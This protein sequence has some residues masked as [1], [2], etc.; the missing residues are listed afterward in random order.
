MS[1]LLLRAITSPQ[2]AIALAAASSCTAFSAR[3]VSC[4]GADSFAQ[5]TFSERTIGNYENRLRRFS[6]PERVFAYF[7]SVKINDE[8]FM[9]RD[10]L[11]RAVT[12]FTYRHGAP[13]SSKN[14][15][16]NARASAAKTSKAVA[17]EYLRRVQ[18]ILLE[19]ENVSPVEMKKLL[20]FRDEQ[21]VDFETH[22]KTLRALEITNAE[23]DQFLEL[24]GCLPSRAKTFFDLVD[25]DGD[26][27]ISYAEYSFFCTLLA[28]PEQHFELAFKMLD[29]DN[30]GQLDHR[31]FQQIMDLMRLRTPAGRQD[32][33]LH[34]DNEP[35]FKH[36]FGEF[37]TKSLSYDEFCAFRRGLKQEI[38]RIQ[39]SFHH[40]Y[41]PLKACLM[42]SCSVH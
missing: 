13:L 30:N 20:A 29:T 10:D 37:A 36:L 40:L 17:D 22:V 14:P 12:P 39:I 8:D 11:A 18:K 34:D 1:R 3:P 35:I 33:S 21:R 6:S 27:L 31:E 32:R 25:A 28:I 26:G 41:L 9:T 23:F 16:F 2:T 7:S 38:M 4:D 42:L 24:Y 19:S 5:P 15:Q